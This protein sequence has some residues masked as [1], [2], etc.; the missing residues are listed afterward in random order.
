MKYFG[1]LTKNLKLNLLETCLCKAKQS[2]DECGTGGDM[3]AGV[4]DA[5]DKI[6]AQLIDLLNIKNI[7]LDEYNRR[8]Q[9]SLS[10]LYNLLSNNCTNVALA[11]LI[12]K[13]TCYQ[14]DYIKPIILAV[15]KCEAI[16]NQLPEYSKKW[17]SDFY[18]PD[19]T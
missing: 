6:T 9:V 15:L 2:L 10:M 11:V 7:S 8:H 19:S 16:V 13:S 18:N 1:L 4:P 17:I 12:G 3:G 14:I 5:Y